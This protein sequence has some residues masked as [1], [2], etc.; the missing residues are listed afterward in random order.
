METDVEKNTHTHTKDEKF[1]GV[2]LHPES[3][4]KMEVF[5]EWGL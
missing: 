5:C 2:G 3:V 4:L 1:T